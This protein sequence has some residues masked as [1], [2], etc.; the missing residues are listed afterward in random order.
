MSSVCGNFACFHRGDAVYARRIL[1]KEYAGEQLG[2]TDCRSV[3]IAPAVAGFVGGYYFGSFG[4]DAEEPQREVLLLDIGT[5]GEM[6]VGN[7]EQIYCCATAV[8]SAFEGAEMAMGMPA[9]VRQ[10]PCLA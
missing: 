4:S 10:Y 7:E 8:G 6:A 1:W 3:Y 2:L 5:N 9:A